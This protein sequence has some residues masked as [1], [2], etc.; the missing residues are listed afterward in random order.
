MGKW[1]RPSATATVQHTKFHTRFFGQ[2]ADVLCAWEMK[3]RRC[4]WQV[5]LIV[6][7][8]MDYLSRLPYRARGWAGYYSWVVCWLDL[9]PEKP[10]LW[11][12]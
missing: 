12:P 4:G 7:A 5:G 11:F 3:M 2:C 6:R 10:H 8:P 9:P 1:C